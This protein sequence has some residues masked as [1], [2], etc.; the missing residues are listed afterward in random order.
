[1]GVC[2]SQPAGKR[3]VTLSQDLPGVSSPASCGEGAVGKTLL[4]DIAG[5]RLCRSPKSPKSPRSP[6]TPKSPFTP[7]SPAVTFEHVPI[8]PLPAPSAE[9][10]ELPPKP[11]EKAQLPIKAMEQASVAA[12]SPSP[13]APTTPKGTPLLLPSA[14]VRS[15]RAAALADFGAADASKGDGG[16]GKAG[17]APLA[18]PIVGR[19]KSA[20][21]LLP[22]PS[23]R[24]TAARL[25]ALD[26][27][28][29]PDAAPRGAMT[30]RAAGASRAPMGFGGIE[31]LPA[32][33]S[34]SPPE[35]G[36]EGLA[37]G[38]DPAHVKVRRNKRRSVT[39]GEAQLLEFRVVADVDAESGE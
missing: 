34:P 18:L 28:S 11:T 5:S 27:A 10:C 36:G 37:E 26:D 30:C 32:E 19:T 12:C 7:R 24:E 2:S 38:A 20:P 23:R 39:F 9:K 1:M 4:D 6:R 8:V 35:G 17:K 25:A 15:R 14:A 22:L 29:A 13:V 31:V 16:D 3:S 33:A 21:L